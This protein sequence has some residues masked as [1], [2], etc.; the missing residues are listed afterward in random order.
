MS[1][2]GQ[3]V[4]PSELRAKLGITAGTRIAI[5]VEEEHLVLEPITVAYIRSL[6]GSMKAPVS[7]VETR[8][9]QHRLEK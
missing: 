2:K 4:I 5:R 9:R 7:M 1:S 8:D 3:V 6:R